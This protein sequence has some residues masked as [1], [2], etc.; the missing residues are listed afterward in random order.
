MRVTCHALKPPTDEFSASSTPAEYIGLRPVRASNNS[1]AVAACDTYRNAQRTKNTA[2]EE[3][4]VGRS[5]QLPREIRPFPNC[6][7]QSANT[8]TTLV[9]HFLVV[10]VESCNIYPALLHFAGYKFDQS[11]PHRS[12]RLPRSPTLTCL[13]ICTQTTMFRLYSI[14]RGPF[15]RVRTNPSY[16]LQSSNSL[17]LVLLR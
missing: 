4:V 1:L 14:W 7:E 8:P 3:R 5:G 6:Y 11:V 9:F 2:G 13:V 12:P 17:Q 10:Y 16:M 15:L